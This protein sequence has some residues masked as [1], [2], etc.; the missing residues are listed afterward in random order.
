MNVY[1]NRI[2]KV[3]DS[4]QRVCKLFGYDY[5]YTLI[6]KLTSKTMQKNPIHLFFREGSLTNTFLRMK[7]L[8]LIMLIS[9]TLVSAKS[10]A[11]QQNYSKL[12][13]QVQ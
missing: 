7:L 9:V 6:L 12:W 3:K 13:S 11:V 10:Y 4:G 5:I 1:G 2:M 8:G